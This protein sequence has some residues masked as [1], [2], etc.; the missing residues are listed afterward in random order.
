VPRLNI[1]A[2][3]ERLARKKMGYGTQKGW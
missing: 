3:E 1:I 2:G